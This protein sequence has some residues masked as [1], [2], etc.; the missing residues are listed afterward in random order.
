MTAPGSASSSTYDALAAVF[1]PED[2][3]SDVRGGVKVTYI[4]GESVISRLNEVLGPAGWS[5]KV[6]E[7]GYHQEA[8][9]LWVLGAIEARIDGELAVRHQFG[10]QK[11]KH[12]RATEQPLD[13]GFDYK[14]ATTDALKKCAMGLGV[15]L[16]LSR[17]EN[18][19]P[20]AP[21][22][23]PRS[24][25][26]PQPARQPT[27]P[28]AAAP[29]SAP[30]APTPAPTPAPAPAPRPADPV[31]EE[32]WQRFQALLTEYRELGLAQYGLDVAFFERV[33]PDAFTRESFKTVGESLRQKGLAAKELKARAAQDGV[34]QKG[35]QRT[36]TPAR[37]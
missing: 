32:Q 31:T 14:G 4:T 19:A 21:R 12:S 27:T 28:A 37:V 13:I 24:A 7:H 15:G 33:D 9:E 18:P 8:D 29:Q 30:P 6:L 23:A 2:L 36:Q 35:G 3:L 17:K 11:I 5:F 26:A 22:S 34:V 20:A 16:Y 25:P 1:P 10:S